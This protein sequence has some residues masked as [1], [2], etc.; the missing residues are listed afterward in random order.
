MKQVISKIK[1]DPSKVGF[2]MKVDSDVLDW[3]KGFGR[4]Y[5]SHINKVLRAYK[6]VC[7]ERRKLAQELFERYYTQCFWH[8]KKDLVI[9][10]DTIPLI[11]EGLRKFGGRHGYIEAEKLC[12]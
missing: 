1:K 9:T 7:D 4:G 8:M 3:F 10:D 5:Q 11:V 2:F 12:P 6:E